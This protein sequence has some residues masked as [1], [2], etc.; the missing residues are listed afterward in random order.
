VKQVVAKKDIVIIVLETWRVL[1]L[2]SITPF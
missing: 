1:E 2:I